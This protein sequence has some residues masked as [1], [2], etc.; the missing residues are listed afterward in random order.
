MEAEI[1]TLLEGRATADAQHRVL[2]LLAARLDPLRLAHNLPTCTLAPGLRLRRRWGMCRHGPRGRQAHIQVRC[3][4]D[5]TPLRWRSLSSI[6]LTLLHE[7]AHLRYRSHGPR[8]WALHRTLVDAAAQSALYR[9]EPGDLSELSQGLERLAGSAADALA[10]AAR[11]RRRTRYAENRAVAQRFAVGQVATFGPRAGRL[12]GWRVTVLAVARSRLTV[13]TTDG[14]RYLVHA[15]LLEAL[16][17][18][19][20]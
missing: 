15:T 20:D 18:Q 19:V 5:G 17:E 6:T 3:T 14:Q 10:A 2:A 1:A 16:I 11:A 8:F 9:A 12:Y 13:R 7:W 4:A